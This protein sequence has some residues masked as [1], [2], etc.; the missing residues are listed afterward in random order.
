MTAGA[1][2]RN[3]D[4]RL[5]RKL[6]WLRETKY[7]AEPSVTNILIYKGRYWNFDDWIPTLNKAATWN[8]WTE[9]NALMQLDGCV[10][11]RALQE[12]NLKSQ[13]ESNTFKL[14]VWPW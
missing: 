9:S 8:D 3:I 1:Y 5:A 14:N 7:N 10:H 6:V 13:S 2:N 4:K 12:W 11:R